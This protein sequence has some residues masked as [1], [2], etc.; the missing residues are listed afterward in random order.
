MRYVIAVGNP[1]DGLTFYVIF[2]THDEALAKAESHSM[3][4]GY[5]IV[6]IETNF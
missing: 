3:F 6:E 5:W 1:F 2:D 4:D